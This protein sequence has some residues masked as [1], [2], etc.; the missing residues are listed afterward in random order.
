GGLGLQLSKDGG[1][2]WNF[3]GNNP[4]ND[5]MWIMTIAASFTNTD[6]LYFATCPDSAHNLKVFFSANEGAN[7][8][9]ITNG[10]PDRYPRR[11]AVNP[12]NSAEVY[13]VFSGFGTGHVFKSL[14]A[15]ANWTDIS[16]ALPN[17]PFEC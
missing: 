10:L 9:D 6:S 3:M 13:I 11:I 15:G 7:V 16:S 17:I 8:T 5:G 12:S 14:N 1:G 4:V 2:T